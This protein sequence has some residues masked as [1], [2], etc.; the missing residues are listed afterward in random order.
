MAQLWIFGG[1]GSEGGSEQV[2]CETEERKF[3][4]SSQQVHTIPRRNT[5]NSAKILKKSK[6]NVKMRKEEKNER[7]ENSRG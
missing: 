3:S 7:K 2:E 5:L 4:S 1:G 6:K